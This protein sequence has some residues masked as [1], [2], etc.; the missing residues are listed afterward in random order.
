MTKKIQS[1]YN[2]KPSVLKPTRPGKK[3]VGVVKGKIKRKVQ[4]VWGT[5][6]VVIQQK[7]ISIQTLSR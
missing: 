2:R 7:G 5:P 3:G 6:G 1:I 4:G